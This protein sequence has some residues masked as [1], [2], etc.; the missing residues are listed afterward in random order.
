MASVTKVQFVN[1]VNATLRVYS[2][3]K[4][5]ATSTDVTRSGSKIT[6]TNFVAVTTGELP[7]ANISGGELQSMLESF[8]QEFALVRRVRFLKNINGVFTYQY[9]RFARI[10][11]PGSPEP[12][13][14]YIPPAAS[15]FNNIQPLNDVDLIKYQ[16]I[17]AVLQGTL[18]TNASTLHANYNYCH[19]SCHSNCHASRGR[20]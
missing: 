17:L 4:K 1:D 18:A 15:T 13:D 20:R 16:N 9:S 2:N 10:V 6:T 8:T 12:N 7:S 14:T 19:S 11:T 5:N 3:N